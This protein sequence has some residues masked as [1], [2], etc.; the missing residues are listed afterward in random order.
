[1]KNVLTQEPTWV[2]AYARGALLQS[3]IWGSEF[4]KKSAIAWTIDVACNFFTLPLMGEFLDL[5]ANSHREATLEANGTF[6][7]S[8]TPIAK[9]GRWVSGD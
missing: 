2:E 1:M 3:W 9:K 6:L 4:R 5:Q 8:V 7:P